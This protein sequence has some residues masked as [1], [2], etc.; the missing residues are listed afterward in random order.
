MPELVVLSY[1]PFTRQVERVHKLEI[2]PKQKAVLEHLVHDHR[3]ESARHMMTSLMEGLEAK[4]SARRLMA[5][6][7]CGRDAV[8]SVHRATVKGTWDGRLCVENRPMLL[9]DRGAC[10]LMSEEYEKVLLMYGGDSH[11]IRKGMSETPCCAS[12]ELRRCVACKQLKE[13]HSFTLAQW[14]RFN[15]CCIFCEVMRGGRKA[16]RG[17]EK[18]GLAPSIEPSDCASECAACVDRM[19][20]YYY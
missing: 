14:V 19:E 9:C 8:H 20:R 7:V 6:S 10:G 11:T 4:Q 17:K 13:S 2:K 5:C 18:E 15:R 3:H 16:C 1:K 12:A